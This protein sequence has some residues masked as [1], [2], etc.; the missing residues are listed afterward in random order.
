MNRANKFFAVMFFGS[1]AGWYFLGS[2]SKYPI[3]AVPIAIL[4]AL[5]AIRS[6]IPA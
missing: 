1:I 2:T 3:L 6:K 4:W 5:Y